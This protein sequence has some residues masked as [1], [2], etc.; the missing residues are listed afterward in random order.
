[1]VLLALILAWSFR[2]DF[3][4][5]DFE[6]LLGTP[7][8]GP[9]CNYT[10]VLNSLDTDTQEVRGVL[11]F[12]GGLPIWDDQ[13]QTIFFGPLSYSDLT[14]LYAYTSIS[15][16][17][18]NIRVLREI[19]L[20]AEKF[21]KSFPPPINFSFKA[22]GNS[23]IYPFDRYFIMGAVACQAYVKKGKRKEYVHTKK[24]AEFLSIKNNAKG[25]FIRHP[26]DVELDQI[27]RVS[28][29]SKEP[30]TVNKEANNR[31]NRFALIMERPYYLKIM[32]AVLGIIALLSAFYIGFKTPFKDVPIQVIGYVI[33][34][35]GIRSILMGDLK[36]FPSY[37]DYALLWMYVLLFAGIVFRKI[38]GVASGKEGDSSNT[39]TLSAD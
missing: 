18:L 34:V 25:L 26:T 17:N 33:G 31:E 32:T 9:Y 37:F 1:L 4:S 5:K 8:K 38:K 14:F 36:I 39:S 10:L 6:R 3:E 13:E 20:P 15:N 16:V 22:L 7:L 19:F 24:D 35:W 30:P 29:I 11:R 12:E 2:Q 27:K 21:T 28:I 23:E